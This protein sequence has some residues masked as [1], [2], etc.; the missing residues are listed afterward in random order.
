MKT[1][2]ELKEDQALLIEAVN[3]L[4][5]ITEE[6]N[7]NTINRVDEDFTLYESWA[8]TD[9]KNELQAKIGELQVLIEYQDGNNDAK[10]DDDDSD[11]QVTELL[12]TTREE[13]EI[14]EE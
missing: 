2:N 3:I 14:M 1:I 12:T 13:T 5:T 11:E 4:D 9:V 8:V 7:D 10:D 6:E